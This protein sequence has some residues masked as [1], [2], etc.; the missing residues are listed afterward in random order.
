MANEKLHDHPTLCF[1]LLFI[2][3]FAKFQLILVKFRISRP[4]T[5][6]L[7]DITPAFPMGVIIF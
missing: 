1:R 4:R 5:T 3:N 7:V 6:V 2:R